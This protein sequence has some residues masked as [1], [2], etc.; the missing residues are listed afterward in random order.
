MKLKIISGI[1]LLLFLFVFQTNSAYAISFEEIKEKTSMTFTQIWE[2]IELVFT[3]KQEGKVDL[4]A[5]QA[6]R[7]VDWAQEEFN[8]GNTEVGQN[9]LDSY[10]SIKKNIADRLE[11]LDETILNDYKEKT[12]IENGQIETMKVNTTTEGVKNVIEE[13][14]SEVL[15]KV[16]EVVGDK[17]GTEAATNFVEIIYAPGTSAG[18]TSKVVIEGGELKYAP[19]TSAGGTSKVVIEGGTKYAPGTEGSNGN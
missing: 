1:L 8:A 9:Y 15:N 11:N 16:W 18:G 13:K 14:Q 19:G 12:I 5:E 2:K 7:R 4:L 10:I 3:F 17:Q 6:Q